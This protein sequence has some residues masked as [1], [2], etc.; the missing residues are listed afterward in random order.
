MELRAAAELGTE[1]MARHGLHGWV[2]TFD[3]ARTRAGVCRPRLR[4]ISLSAHLTRLHPEDE[5]RDT[6]LHEI[7]HALVGAEHGHDEAWQAKALAIGSSGQRCSS[8]D[9]PRIE[10]SWVGR[11]ANG[12]L[13]HRHRRPEPVFLCLRCAGPDLQ[14]IFDW[15]YGGYPAP[16]HPNYVAELDSLMAGVP[17]FPGR[18]GPGHV[19]RISA[20]GP[21]EGVVG[22][23][24]RRGRTRYTVQVEGGILSVPFAMVELAG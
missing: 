20:P 15:T 7:A 5:V 24:V 23:I 10:G 19:V 13:T 1:L 3:R 16:M 17:R 12:H 22:P 18:F 8:A 11:C 4:Q 2:L 21:Y 14:R 9:A 6:I